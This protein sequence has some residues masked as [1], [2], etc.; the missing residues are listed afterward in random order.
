MIQI[1]HFSHLS[2]LFYFALEKDEENYGKGQR[3]PVRVICLFIYF[4]LHDT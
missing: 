4:F 3:S 2:F 1:P